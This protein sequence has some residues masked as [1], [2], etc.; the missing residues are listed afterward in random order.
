MSKPCRSMRDSL[1]AY[2]DARLDARERLEVE[3]H[4]ASC[5]AC[6]AELE[7][8]RTTTGLVRSLSRPAAPPGFHEDL[9][10]RVRAEAAPAAA[11]EGAGARRGGRLRRLLDAV[12]PRR[13]STVA[14][15]AVVAAAAVV[16]VLWT[17]AF[18]HY[19][20]VDVPGSQ[21]LGLADR[22]A[23][24][25][26][27]PVGS[28][29]A[30][31]GGSVGQESAADKAGSTAGG[32]GAGGTAVG[33]G[34]GGSSP[35]ASSGTGGGAPG[36][37]YILS[38]WLTLECP[39]VDEAR[40]RAVV[41]VETA[42]GF[43][44]SWNYWKD[45]RGKMVASL[46]LRVPSSSLSTVLEQIRVLGQVLGEQAYRQDVTSQYVDLEAR[47]KN[48]RMQEQSLLGLLG[49]AESLADIFAIQSELARVRSEIESN[50]SQLRL[51]AEQ[52]ELSTINL[53]LQTEGPGAADGLWSRLVEAFLRSLRWLVRLGEGLLVF[54]AGALV[55]VTLLAALAWLGYRVY[56]SRRRRAA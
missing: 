41:V 6:A 55:P 14:R 56:Q 18:L 9:L 36:R 7:A 42:G 13:W 4:L 52:V 17:G 19:M 53:S 51:L 21:Y 11:V 2:L 31:G 39:D 1:H 38:A 16:L 37:K 22:Q 50:E 23:P 27:Q 20:G 8:L 24:G 30:P 34:Y 40:A 15:T 32:P 3:R 44:E 29:V 5:P 49:R 25:A 33:P 47:V 46:V 12:A 43:A 35:S 48:L 45:E 28:A 10:R 54:L 26:G